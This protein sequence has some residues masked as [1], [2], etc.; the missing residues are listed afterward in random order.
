MNKVIVPFYSMGVDNE[1]ISVV[2][3]KYDK[4]DALVKYK[5]IKHYT[6]EKADKVYR[7]VGNN[8]LTEEEF[9]EIVRKIEGKDPEIK[10]HLN[11]VIKI[12]LT[13]YGKDIYYHQY[14]IV[15]ERNK[16][17]GRTLIKPKMPDV[18][19]EGYTRMLLWEF[20]ELFGPHTHFGDTKNYIDPIEIIKE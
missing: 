2:F 12:K 18:D 1:C 5:V 10:I 20:M 17:N 3:F 14:D 6:N 9:N 13:D 8:E 19:A 11:D 15:N 16:A 7:L 4:D